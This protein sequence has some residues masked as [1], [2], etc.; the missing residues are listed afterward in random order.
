MPKP[1]PRSSRKYPP[2]FSTRDAGKSSSYYTFSPNWKRSTTAT[3]ATKQFTFRHQFFGLPEGYENRVTLVV[4]IVALILVLS[5]VKN[6]LPKPVM[7]FLAPPVYGQELD[8]E[9][10]LDGA[11]PLRP[12]CVFLLKAT[13]IFWLM[14]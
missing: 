9:R 14:E 5:V 1:Y 7:E 6:W 13:K 11:K 2:V 10:P 12:G 8:P 4:I 3:D